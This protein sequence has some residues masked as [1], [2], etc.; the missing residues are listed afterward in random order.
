MDIH[1][2]IAAS[3]VEKNQF[4]NL[5][6]SNKNGKPWASPVAFWVDDQNC[7]YFVSEITSRHVVN[8]LVNP[9][10][11]FSIFDSNVAEGKGNMSGLQ[12]GTIAKV[13]IKDNNMVLMD[14]YEVLVAL[15]A[16]KQ[17]FPEANLND[18]KTRFVEWYSNNRVVVQLT[19]NDNEIFLNSFDGK[20][21]T[22]IPVKFKRVLKS[23]I[24][25][26]KM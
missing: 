1:C 5:A 2:E 26:S 24:A 17:K 6:T 11:A 10:V 16:L 8:L 7:F 3:I 20:K 21:D 22:R 13:F 25:R 23:I 12:I 19:P 4:M 18:I 14:D 15:K 9:H